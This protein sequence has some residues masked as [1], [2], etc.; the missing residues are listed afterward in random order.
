M[1]RRQFI[2]L[3]SSASVMA[4]APFQ[5]QAAFKT[6]LP[7]LE[8]PDVSD[9]KLV[10]I[11]LNGGNDGLN[12]L[13]PIDQYE[14]YKELRPSVYVPRDTEANGYMHLDR[15]LTLNQQMGLHPSA[16][17]LKGLYENNLL[18]IIHNVGYPSPNKSHFKSTDLYSTGND[19]KANPAN[20]LQSGWMGRFFE[21]AY[22]ELISGGMHPPGIQLGTTAPSLG[23]KGE[24]NSALAMNLK[25]QDI[26]NFYNGTASGLNGLS[27]V[28]AP[29]MGSLDTDYV[30]N[31]KFVNDI[32]LASNLYAGTI[33]SK[34][35]EGERLEPA[36][37]K[38]EQPEYKS[39]RFDDLTNQLRTVARLIRG[40]LETKIY[41]V[42]ISGFDTHANQV[43]DGKAIIGR[44]QELLHDLSYA[45]DAFMHDIS[46]DSIHESV[47]GITFSEFGRKA[48]QNGN[49]GTDHGQAAPMF[50]FG[51]PV[52]GGVSGSNPDLSI[53]SAENN[54][55][56]EDLDYDYRQVFASLLQ[57]FLGANDTAVDNAFLDY[58]SVPGTPQS[59]TNAK[60]SELLKEEY[61]LSECST[62][63][64][65]NPSSIE[66]KWL[67]HPNPVKDII[68]FS[69]TIKNASSVSYKVYNTTGKLLMSQTNTLEFGQLNLSL[70][71][72][73]SGLYFFQIKVNGSTEVHKVVKI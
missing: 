17:P 18:R 1:K 25:G 20:S 66:K 62:F 30:N 19:G 11:F 23:F 13:V 61:D 26:E 16:S 43:E 7:F 22:P 63:S 37:V 10:V 52:E 2:K 38:Y 55:Q 41:M 39:L 42:Q 56:I 45:V 4:L 36:N 67:L 3:S 44:H 32:D 72:L 27:G 60:I 15:T 46:Q 33:T 71:H 35:L 9:R 49:D 8:C 5:V 73:T 40:G 59:F 47:V 31:L 34:Y 57:N 53:P 21:A 12:T 54:Y 24:I 65:N 50:A 58:S 28:A 68:N 64:N 48:A 70:K 14:R 51:T 6:F 29:S 69:T